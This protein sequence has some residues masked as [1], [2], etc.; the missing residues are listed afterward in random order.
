MT[1]VERF[2]PQAREAFRVATDE[3]RGRGDT[4]LLPA[5]L[6]LGILRQP[7]CLG[8]QLLV[9][10]AVATDD[11]YERVD[12]TLP[13]RTPHSGIVTPDPSIAVLVTHAA[14][15]AAN[16][17]APNV[18]TEHLLL[19]LLC[20]GGLA[21]LQTDGAQVVA[22]RQY[23]RPSLNG[24]P[25]REEAAGGGMRA[26]G[27]GVTGP[28]GN[29][30]HT[31]QPPS[32]EY[33]SDLG[34]RVFA[35]AIE[36]AR[37]MHHS[38]LGAEHLLLGL[39]CQP[40]SAD[41]VAMASLGLTEAATRGLVQAWLGAGF[42][43]S[44]TPLVLNARGRDA[45]GRAYEIAR[46]WG[47][48]QVDSPHILLGILSQPGGVAD[49]LTHAGIAPQQISLRLAHI[50]QGRFQP[51]AV[52]PPGGI[53]VI[54]TALEVEYNAVRT[55]LGNLQA[56]R[57]PAGTIFEVGQ[58]PGSPQPIAICVMGEG[59]QTAGI[60]TERAAGMF[61]PKA[62]LFVGVAGALHDDI[63]IGDI[64]VGTRVYYYHGGQEDDSGFH[65]RPR[66]WDAP[67]DLEQLARYVAR[68]GSWR[69]WLTGG[70]PPQSTVHFRPIAAG[71]V[72]LNSRTS[73]LATQIMRHYNDS[74]AIEMEGAGV[75]RAAHLNRSM[76]A[77]IIRGV[78][79]AA[80]GTKT[81]AADADW[82][83]MAAASAAAFAYEL[84]ASLP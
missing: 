74:A 40:D 47:A 75:A 46:D 45:L 51:T 81:T 29:P 66:S 76:A 63:R 5:H 44:E 6:L 24:T 48:P 27:I 21:A 17:G 8:H 83:P 14:G 56:V 3:A 41:A 19:A 34:K 7:E 60:I 82:Q 58:L 4:R 15:E 9:A 37:A 64:V 11:M 62:V 59:T 72:V 50:L 2:T 65:S 16:L 33:Y 70:G 36:E 52:A 77:L 18:G 54:L 22:I 61:N 43:V 30:H 39:L 42:G 57:H 38:R 68:G 1:Q 78:S 13:V 28:P 84:I 23:L 79:D 10:M 69:R 32:L 25:P 53:V 71:D 67:N 12:L 26:D 80:D 73:P 55:A 35:R 20:V 49:M 31:R